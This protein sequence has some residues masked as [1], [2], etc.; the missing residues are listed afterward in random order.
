VPVV[1]IVEGFAG[2]TV[3]RGAASWKEPVMTDDASRRVRE[4]LNEV[5]AAWEANDAD[6]FAKPYAEP[7]TA[8]LPGAYLSGGPAIRDTMAALFAGGLRGSRA[9]CE[10]RKIR[11]VAADAIVT[12]GGAVLLAG[13]AEPDA[14][15]RAVE[16]WVLSRRDGAW[17]VQAFHNCPE[18][19]NRDAQ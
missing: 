6:A 18:Q 3:P 16:T 12:S 7:A 14:A 9:I 19:V 5:Y 4:V 11:F 17:R 13:Q 15:G 10:V 1:C 2:L 8:T